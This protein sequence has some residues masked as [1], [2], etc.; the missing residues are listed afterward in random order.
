MD[1]LHAIGN[2]SIVRL[3]RVVPLNCAEIFVKLEW[4]NPT[5]KRQGPDGAGRD[6][7]RRSRTAG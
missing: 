7:R 3:H 2:T 4:E 5:G 1:V 6:R